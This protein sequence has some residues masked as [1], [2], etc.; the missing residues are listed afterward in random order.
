MRDTGRG[1]VFCDV[2]VKE[3]GVSA[4]RSR[5]FMYNSSQ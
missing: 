2:E 1:L 4:D 5:G 3:K